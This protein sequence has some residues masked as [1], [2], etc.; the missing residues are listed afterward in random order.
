[1]GIARSTLY[2]EQPAATDDTAIVE[3]MS[4]ICE[5]FERYGWRRVRAALRQ[6]GMVVNHK[7]VRRLMREHDLQPRMRRR[8][9]TTTDS[10]HDQPIFANLAMDMRPDGPDQLWVADITYV[11]IIGGFVYVRASGVGSSPS[12]RSSHVSCVPGA[13]SRTAHGTWTKCSSGSAAG[14]CISGV[15]WMPK[16]RCS[17]YWSNPNGTGERLRSSCASC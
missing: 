14:R 2:D 15:R 9:T 16:A 6:R 11:P 4:G 12:A 3:A 17:R 5:E 1:M 10:D 8:Y 13:R 7:K